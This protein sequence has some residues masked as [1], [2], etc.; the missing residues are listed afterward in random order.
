MA[1]AHHKV[2]VSKHQRP[3]DPKIRLRELPRV[4]EYRQEVIRYKRRIHEALALAELD[5]RQRTADIVADLT[6]TRL[7]RR[8]T[9]SVIKRSPSQIRRSVTMTRGLIQK[10]LPSTHKHSGRHRYDAATPKSYPPAAQSTYRSSTSTPAN[11]V[12]RT[13]I[14]EHR[15]LLAIKHSRQALD[16]NP[17]CSKTYESPFYSPV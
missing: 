16:L 14:E 15:K 13:S 2:R 12:L 3:K 7:G 5:V 10:I 4:K 9:N 6:P 11:T 8:R 17:Y 1:I